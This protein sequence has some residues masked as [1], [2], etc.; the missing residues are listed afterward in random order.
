[1]ARDVEL[2]AIS[3]IDKK[4]DSLDARQR[5]RVIRFIVDRENDRLAKGAIAAGTQDGLTQTEP[6]AH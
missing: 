2:I 6:A 4:L 1:M 3:A 5:E